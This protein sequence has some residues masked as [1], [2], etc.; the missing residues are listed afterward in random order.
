MGFFWCTACNENGTANATPDA[1]DSGTIH[2]SADESF[3]PVIDEQVKV[4]ESN[5]P[6]AKILVQY[7]P[8]AACLQDLGV[9]SI[10]MIITTRKL[11]DD[12]TAFVIDSFKIEPE[13][14]VIAYDAIAVIVNPASPDSFLQWMN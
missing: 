7:K 12:E 5:N 6:G 10:R 1:R 11:M 4:Y 14:M 3:K 2:I 8:E 13:S 9:D